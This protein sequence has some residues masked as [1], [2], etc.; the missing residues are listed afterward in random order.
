MGS[1]LTAVISLSLESFR[2]KKKN[3][4]LE[5]SII[6][7]LEYNEYRLNKILQD[8]KDEIENFE[9]GSK[10]IKHPLPMIKTDLWDNIKILIDKKILGDTYKELIKLI[11]NLEYINDHLKMRDNY[12]TINLN[13]SINYD[14]LKSIDKTLIKNIENAINNLNELS[15]SFS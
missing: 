4:E 5:L 15:I 7:E 14:N 12:V 6:S 10:S 8:L 13:N 1:S 3:K 9:N 11:S 2:I